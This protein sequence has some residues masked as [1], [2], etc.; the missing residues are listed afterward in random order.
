MLKFHNEVFITT[1]SIE[2]IHSGDAYSRSSSQ[3]LLLSYNLDFL[4]WR[5]THC[6][7]SAMSYSVW[8]VSC[9]KWQ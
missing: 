2:H 3:I 6:R 7:L 1:N 9:L 8:R 5:T 4:S